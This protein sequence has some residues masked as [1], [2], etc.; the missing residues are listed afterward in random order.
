MTYIEFIISI[1]VMNNG[2]NKST[3]SAVVKS[4][5]SVDKKATID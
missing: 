5:I 2:L 3:I 1:A 4:T